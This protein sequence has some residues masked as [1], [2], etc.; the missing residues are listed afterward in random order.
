MMKALFTTMRMSFAG[1]GRIIGTFGI[2][3]FVIRGALI[4]HMLTPNCDSTHG[5]FAQEKPSDRLVRVQKQFTKRIRPILEKSCGDCHWGDNDDAGVNLEPFKTMDQLLDSRKLWRKVL[6]RVAAREM[7]PEDSEPLTDEE[8]QV[9]TEWVDDL[10]N[11]VDCTNINSGRVTIRRLNRTEYR[12]TIRDLFGYDYRPARAFPGDDVG[13]G[14]DNI[15]DVLSL[16]PRLMEKYL[17]AAEHIT[18]RTIVDPNRG[19]YTKKISGL[20]FRGSD[21]SAK[22]DDMHMIFSEGSISHSI[23]VPRAGT[24]RVEI[25]VQATEAGNELIKMGVG[26]ARMRHKTIEVPGSAYERRTKVSTNLNLETGVQRLS[27]S[28]LNDFYIPAK[29]GREARDRNL[30][31][32]EVTIHG[33]LNNEGTFRTRWLP[34][35]PTKT[36]PSAIDAMR[37]LEKFVSRAWR[38][39]VSDQELGRLMQLYRRGAG[40]HGKFY[41]GLRACVQ[42]VLVS[43]HFLFKVESPP[44]G[45][46]SPKQQRLNDYQLATRLS[47]FLWSTMPD[48]RLFDL[49]A[50]RKLQQPEILI[51]EV[52]RMLADPKADA[53][54]NNFVAQWLQLPSITVSRALMESHSKKLV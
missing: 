25:Q 28:F 48:D 50:E 41:N 10:L 38:R 33:P 46:A 16:P 22:H 29:D 35:L 42:A 43:P 45:D 13:Y 24:Y 15:A 4:L 32:G 53:L 37:T 2:L 51:A 1:V 11:S 18:T 44:A 49:A 6:T 39:P 40:K 34:D 23:N 9:V 5:L 7:P 52:K 12:N 54:V 47:Y 20:D 17:D 30:L 3:P 14:F 36:Q 21:A 19:Q 26:L 8:H 27:L 31:I